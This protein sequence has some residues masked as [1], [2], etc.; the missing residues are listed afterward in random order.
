MKMLNKLNIKKLLLPVPKSMN[1]IK[2]AMREIENQTCIN[3]R[4][5]KLKDTD[6]VRFISEPGLVFRASILFPIVLGKK[7]GLHLK[8]YN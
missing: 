6:Y 5:K 1:V 8:H 3:F 2:K 4:R 7:H